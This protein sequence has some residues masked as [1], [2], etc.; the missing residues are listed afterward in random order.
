MKQMADVEDVRLFG[1]VR[2]GDASSD[3]LFLD[4]EQKNGKGPDSPPSVPKEKR[5][6]AEI[7]E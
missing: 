1:C 5:T 4:A 7:G 2:A 3:F 6:E